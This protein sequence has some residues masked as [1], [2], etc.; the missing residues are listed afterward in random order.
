[1]K[2]TIDKRLPPGTDPKVVQNAVK[3]VSQK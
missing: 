1:L 3:N 2:Q